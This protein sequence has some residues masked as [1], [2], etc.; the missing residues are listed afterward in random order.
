MKILYFTFIENS[1]APENA[2]VMRGQV[3]N[4]LKSIATQN[5]DV[6]VY[7]LSLINI[8]NYKPS[9]DEISAL[10]SELKEANVTLKI[11]ELP[12]GKLARWSFAKDQLSK[13]A[14]VI[15]PD[16]VH[17]RVYPSTLVALDTRKKNKF[18]FKVIFDARGVYP[19]QIA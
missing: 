12:S 8:V 3:I 11:I 17:C 2:G 4:V 7:W 18:S 1:F 19:E 14:S 5:N 16:I 9:D 10:K 6:E 13:Y 15:N